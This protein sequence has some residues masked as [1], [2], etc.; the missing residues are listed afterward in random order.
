MLQESV[1]HNEVTLLINER[2][3]EYLLIP[4]LDNADLS[5]KVMTGAKSGHK[6]SPIQESK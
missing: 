3:A 1:R 6:E 5:Q 4:R 2:T